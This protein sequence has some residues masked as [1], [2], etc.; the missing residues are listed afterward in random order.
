MA[1]TRNWS[2][3]EDVVVSLRLTDQEAWLV[4]HLLDNLPEV[5]S[6]R[7]LETLDREMQN[8]LQVIL[9]DLYQELI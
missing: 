8:D 5:H 1:V 2:E 7:G 3:P 9:N 6:I 4:R